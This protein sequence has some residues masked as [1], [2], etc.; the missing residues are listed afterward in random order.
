MHHSTGAFTR[1]MEMM[2]TQRPVTNEQAM[3]A[4]RRQIANVYGGREAKLCIPAQ[5]DDD[6]LVVTRYIKEQAPKRK[7]PGTRD[8]ELGRERASGGDRWGSLTQ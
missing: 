8:R 4:A 2:M 3:A 1:L 5:L 7:A 6:D